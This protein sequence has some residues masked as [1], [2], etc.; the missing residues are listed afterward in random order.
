M[1]VQVPTQPPT[2][3]A[4]SRIGAPIT[5][6]H[7]YSPVAASRNRVS[8]SYSASSPTARCQA[9]RTRGAS[10]RCCTSS[11]ARTGLLAGQPG[12][13]IEPLVGEQG[14]AVGGRLPHEC[15][16]ILG[17]RAEPLLAGAERRVGT[18]SLRDVPDLD[19]RAGGLAGLVAER[20]G[21]ERDVITTTA[22]VHEHPLALH[23]FPDGE[24]TVHRGFRGAR[25]AAAA[26][27]DAL[28]T[29]CSGRRAPPPA[30]SPSTALPRGS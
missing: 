15:R 5:R 17:Q 4:A 22:L 26:R 28:T 8:T 3:P 12:V 27:G 2:R 1:S 25:A 10:S 16:L 23:P 21:A 29:S 13:A 11:Q 14:H 19:H 18:L 9:A 6:N 20:A 7:R 30:C 24:G